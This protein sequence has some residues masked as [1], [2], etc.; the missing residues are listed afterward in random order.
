MPVWYSGDLRHR[1]I[2]AWEAKEGSQRQLAQRFTEDDAFGWFNH[3][4]LFT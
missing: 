2:I 1:V 4:G 3:C